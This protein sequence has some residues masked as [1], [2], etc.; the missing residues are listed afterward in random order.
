MHAKKRNYL[1]SVDSETEGRSVPYNTLPQEFVEATLRHAR[2]SIVVLDA[3]RAHSRSK[4]SRGM[5]W[6]H[7]QPKAQA[8]KGM[9]IAYGSGEGQT[10]RDS[11]WSYY[12]WDLEYGLKEPGLELQ[13]V[14]QRVNSRQSGRNP[15]SQTLLDRCREVFFVPKADRTVLSPSPPN[16][17]CS[18]TNEDELKEQKSGQISGSIK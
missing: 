14:F 1:L 8:D 7:S 4:R 5:G 17:G 15:E 18:D 2:L 13:E 11:A 6:T 16:R 12:E 9:L 10:L 3:C